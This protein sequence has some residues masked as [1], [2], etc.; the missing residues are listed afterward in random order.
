MN[1]FEIVLVECVWAVLVMLCDSGVMPLLIVDGPFVFLPS[2]F[3]GA[4]RLANV[5]GFVGA[6]TRV[7]IHALLL[8]F[9]WM[10][11]ITAA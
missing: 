10:R 1:Y 7:T 4:V 3:T 11:L 2:G 5:N 8:F 6:L 9:G